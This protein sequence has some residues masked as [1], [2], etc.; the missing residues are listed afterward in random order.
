MPA[1]EINWHS[2]SLILAMPKRVSTKVFEN[3]SVE[4]LD[5]F[6]DSSLDALRTR[7]SMIAYG[8]CYNR[9]S[10]TD[11][12]EFVDREAGGAWFCEFYAI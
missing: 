2:M 8:C 11:L 12:F 3:S 7:G 10:I 9:P 1:A 5:V 4:L 6:D